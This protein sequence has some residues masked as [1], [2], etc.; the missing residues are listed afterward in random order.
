MHR[1][2]VILA[3]SA[4][5]LTACSGGSSGG[6]AGPDKAGTST[7][8]VAP[9]PTPVALPALT[10]SYRV[11]LLVVKSDTKQ[12]AAGSRVTR[13]WKFTPLCADPTCG[14]TLSRQAGWYSPNGTAGTRYFPSTATRI[15]DR[16][17]GVEKRLTQCREPNGTV[18]TGKVQGTFTYTIDIVASTTGSRPTFTGTTTVVGSQAGT[19]KGLHQT[20]TFT[21]TPA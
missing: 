16:Y 17:Q 2:G 15:G 10:G 5:L 9:S 4:A 20:F 19:C 6:S 21:G 18:V 14:V 8:T 12:Q 3:L 11:D 1:R 7:P 13:T